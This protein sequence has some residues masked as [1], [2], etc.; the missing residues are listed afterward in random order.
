MAS[1]YSKLVAGVGSK[2]EEEEKKN[3]KGSGLY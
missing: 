3:G 1:T 2:E